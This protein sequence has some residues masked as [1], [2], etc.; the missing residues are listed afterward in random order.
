MGITLS[1]SNQQ[2]AAKRQE[3][4]HY[5]LPTAGSKFG[6]QGLFGT[7]SSNCCLWTSALRQVNKCEAFLVYRDEQPF[8]VNTRWTSDTKRFACGSL[9]RLVDRSHKSLPTN[10]WV[11]SVPSSSAMLN[12]DEMKL[13]N[14]F[15]W[16]WSYWILLMSLVNC[17]FSTNSSCLHSPDW[18]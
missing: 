7:G 2:P 13:L 16:G 15:F 9:C 10:F 12:D 8:F 17:R 3:Q 5:R 14:L 18:A 6:S 1:V 11:Q 4:Q